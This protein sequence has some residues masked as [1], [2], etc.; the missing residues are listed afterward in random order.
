MRCPLQIPC[1][2]VSRFVCTNIF[3]RGSCFIYLI[4]LLV[5]VYNTISICRSTA[6]QQVPLV[7]QK[8]FIILEHLSSNTT[9]L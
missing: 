6:T 8:L 2:H 1:K 7:K 3:R 4:Y 5:L 9:F